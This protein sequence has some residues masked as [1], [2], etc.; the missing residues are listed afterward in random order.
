MESTVNIIKGDTIGLDT[1]Y[2]D[3]LPVNMYAVNKDILGAAGYL[4]GIPGLTE[5]GTPT[6]LDRGAVYNERF[7]IHF[8]V[9]GQSLISVGNNGD[10]VV[11][12][13]IPGE[14]QVSMPYSFNTQ[15]IVADGRMFLYSPSGGLIEITD[16]DLGQPLDAVWIDGYYLMV[17]G[18]N[19]YHTDIADESSIVPLSFGTAEFMPD[20][21]LAIAKTQDNKAIIFG[22]GSIEYF[23]DIAAENFAF[24]RIPSRSQKIG[25]VSTH[26]VCEVSG[27]FYL[28]GGREKESIGLHVITVGSSQKVST[29]DVDAIFAQ[30]KEHELGDIRVESRKEQDTTFV[31]IHLKNHTLCF[32]ETIAG[33]LGIEY[34]WTELR[35]DEDKYRAI[36]GVFDPRV[37]LFV[38]GDR[39]TS[40]LGYLDRSHFSQYGESQEFIL[41]TPFIALNGKSIDEVELNTIPGRNSTDDATI[42]FSMTL[43]GLTYSR[44]SWQLYG[45]Q[46]EYGR[47]FI[48][49]RLGYVSNWL[50]FRFRGRTTS[51]LSFSAMRLKYA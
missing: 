41:D 10:V 44:E 5:F 20:D 3:S 12:G 28:V 4:V 51:R 23:D 15:A 7:D 38:Y 26:A 25:I 14:R 49:L 18:E 17:D 27:F 29:K 19:V 42:A 33:K 34:A 40:K 48:A 21:S 9:S 46:K 13:T 43:D 45:N 11:L 1:E 24:T 2:K 36:N 37:A 30:Y 39:L 8:R 32:N 16:E 50:G 47:R 22:R 35:T 6:G 31:I